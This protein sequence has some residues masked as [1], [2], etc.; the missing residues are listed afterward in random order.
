MKGSKL[1][2]LIQLM[3]SPAWFIE[4][5]QQKIQSIDWDK[6]VNDVSSFLNIQDKKALNLWGTNFFM[7]KL[8]KLEN[9]LKT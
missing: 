5:M 2:L 8:N 7:D 6:A 3:I 9:V 1:T 4:V